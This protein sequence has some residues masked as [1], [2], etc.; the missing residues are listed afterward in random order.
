M[1]WV[2]AIRL[3]TLHE[4]TGHVCSVIGAVSPKVKD[5]GIHCL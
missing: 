2:P 3:E 5:M 4:F 1:S